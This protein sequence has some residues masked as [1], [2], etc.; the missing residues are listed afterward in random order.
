MQRGHVRVSLLPR[1][2][3]QI[4]AVVP[5]DCVARQEITFGEGRVRGEA[6]GTIE[7]RVQQDCERRWVS[8]A[9][10]TQRHDGAQIASGAVASNADSARVDTEL[11]CMLGAPA[12]SRN[13]ILGGGGK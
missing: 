7:R 6:P 11:G 1:V 13:R 5:V 9:R 8:V 10:A 2:S 3:A 12:I 4:V